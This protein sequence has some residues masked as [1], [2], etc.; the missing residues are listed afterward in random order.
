MQRLQFGQLL[1]PK[2][3]SK[4]LDLHPECQ[5]ALFLNRNTVW[6]G[7]LECAPMEIG[8]PTCWTEISRRELD[9]L[10]EEE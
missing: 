6:I 3:A 5:K 2:Q 1:S 9:K 10:A 7:D 8:R 4:W